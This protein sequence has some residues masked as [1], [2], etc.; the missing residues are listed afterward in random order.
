MNIYIVWDHSRKEYDEEAIAELLDVFWSEQDAETFIDEDT[1][2]GFDAKDVTIEERKIKG[3][4]SDI[5]VEN[6]VQHVLAGTRGGMRVVIGDRTP[7]Q[8]DRA[9]QMAGYIASGVRRAL[10]KLGYIK[11]N[12]EPQATQSAP[13]AP[14][15]GAAHG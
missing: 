4:M 11:E 6:L 1:I 9:D 8:Y 3:S 2:Y 5:D 7:K 14:D 13:Q 10:T 15:Q 12:D